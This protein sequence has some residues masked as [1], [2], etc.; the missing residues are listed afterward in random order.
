MF[1]NEEIHEKYTETFGRHRRRWRHCWSR[2]Q[3]AKMMMK[4][5]KIVSA[6]LVVS[7]LLVAF[8]RESGT[9]D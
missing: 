2:S 7:V 9:A 5:G 1:K 8:T 4:P 6:A 3:R